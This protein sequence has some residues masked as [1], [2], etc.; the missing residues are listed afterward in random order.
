MGL[1]PH[2]R[3]R[4]STNALT[5]PG[6]GQSL[7]ESEHRRPC[8]PATG[9]RLKLLAQTDLLRKDTSRY[10][11]KTQPERFVT[12]LH[13]IALGRFGHGTPASRDDQFYW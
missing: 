11:A 7:M 10:P 8:A 9:D 4:T 5:L 12:R 13:G 6:P 3:A 2:N 1:A